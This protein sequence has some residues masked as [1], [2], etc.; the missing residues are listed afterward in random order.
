M[1]LSTI[2]ERPSVKPLRS[3]ETNANAIFR[4]RALKPTPLAF[5]TFSHS[6]CKAKIKTDSKTTIRRGEKNTEIRRISQIVGNVFRLDP[7]EIPKT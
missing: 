1:H 6:K 2:F 4:F 3:R 5:Q 7:M